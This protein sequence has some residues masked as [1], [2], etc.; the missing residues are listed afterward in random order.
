MKKVVAWIMTM[1]LALAAPLLGGTAAA[2]ANGSGSSNT[3]G[4]AS[5]VSGSADTGSQE[6][7]DDDEDEED[8]EEDKDDEDDEDEDEDE[9][10]DEDEDGEGKG[11]GKKRGL[12][13]AIESLTKN[14]ED[15]KG[16]PSD[17][18][19]KAVIE[20]LQAKL[21]TKLQESDSSEGEEDAEEALEEALEDVLDELEEEEIEDVE[22]ELE[23]DV[24]D[25]TATEEDVEVL[26]TI[27]IKGKKAEEAQ[28]DLE[29]A[30][31][32][33]PDS[34]KLYELLS[35][36]FKEQGDT[37][38]VKVY[39]NGKKPV[40]D[41]KPVIKEGRT[42]V[43]VRAITEALGANVEYDEATQTVII[44]KDGKKIELP[45]GSTTIKVNGEE[46]TIDKAAELTNGRTLVPVRFISEYLGHKV[47][48]DETASI[49]IV[50]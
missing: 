2:K 31:S 39:V 21:Q 18:A 13:R 32:K 26:V 42:L 20:K 11:K 4:S 28:A 7:I 34:D 16:T 48:F 19:L 9:E 33:K 35:K 43:P 47:E 6:D 27:K 44:E 36:V 46:K 1:L 15:G 40:M 41:V 17:A 8:E 14:L 38:E 23:A 25:G 30:L 22:E 29:K 10:E 12:E 49:V 5:N 24:E 37:Q 50:K 3:T 45:L